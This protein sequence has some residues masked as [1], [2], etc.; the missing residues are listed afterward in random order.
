M[1]SSA[2]TGQ[3]EG[4]GWGGGTI[5]E[6]I[7]WLTPPETNNW[8]IFISICERLVVYHSKSNQG[9]D[10][11]SFNSLLPVLHD[12]LVCFEAVFVVKNFVNK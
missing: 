1:A 8:K 11:K 6:L 3:V 12:S 10:K 2:G 5:E 9:S 4:G 7:N